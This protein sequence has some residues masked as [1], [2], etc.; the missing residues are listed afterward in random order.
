MKLSDVH[1]QP[2]NPFPLLIRIYKANNP[3]LGFA[4]IFIAF[5]LWLPSFFTERSIVFQGAA[6]PLYSAI[7]SVLISNKMLSSAIS[8]LLIAAEAFLLNFIVQQFHLQR[9]QTWLPGLVYAILMSALP[10]ALML[11]PVIFA[12]LFLILAVK[13]GFDLSANT[14]AA[15]AAFDSAFLISIGSLF[16]FPVALFLFFTWLSIF[17]FRAFSLREAIIAV[18]GFSVPYFFAATYFYLMD[19]SAFFWK[20]TILIPLISKMPVEHNML[21]SFYVLLA[22]LALMIVLSVAPFLNEMSRNKAGIRNGLRL[23]IW[24][25]LFATIGFFMAPSWS[26]VH[27]CL[28]AI[29]LSIIF[30]TMFFQQKPAFSETVFSLLLMVIIIY[31]LNYF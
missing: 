1:H 25:G 28:A 31:H 3:L 20:D 16:Y 29:P 14:N 22:M 12:N 4:L 7:P 5:L 27:F 2:I 8:I 10:E 21:S 18:V 23:F 11:H 13:R 30:S 17:A 24:F 6:M 9:N 15:S 26:V 19:E